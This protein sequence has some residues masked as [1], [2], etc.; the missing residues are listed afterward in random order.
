MSQIISAMISCSL[1]SWLFPVGPQIHTLPFSDLL[2]IYGPQYLTAVSANEFPRLLEW[3]ALGWFYQW[4]SSADQ[5]WGEERK[6]NKKAVNVIN[7]SESGKRW[8]VGVGN[9]LISSFLPS[10]GGQSSEQRRFRLTDR[11]EGFSEAGRSV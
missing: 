8:G 9:V 4:V 2:L 1:V 7:I 3:M 11:E 5:R 10:T 6:Q